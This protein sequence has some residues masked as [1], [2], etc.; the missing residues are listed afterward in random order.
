MA[1]WTKV[2]LQRE[3]Q[4]AADNGWI[5]DFQQAATDYAF[6]VEVLVAIASRESDMRNIVGD[7]GHGFGIMQIDD[8]SFPDWCH[9][10]AWKDAG[11]GIQRGALVLD[12]K[13]EQVRSGQGKNLSVGGVAFQGVA[14]L[15][16]EDLLRIAVAAYNCGLWAYCSF[17]QE[18]DPDL[19]STQGDY[20]ADTLLRAS[21]FR[22][23]LA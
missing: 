23:L 4:L 11:A 2:D 9:S 20:S 22:E 14:N 8:R 5:A 19:K 7:G 6:P 16:D 21:V 15:A 10:G 3:F 12:S 13:R 1:N 17:S 18:G